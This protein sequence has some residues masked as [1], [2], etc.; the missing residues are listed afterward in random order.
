MNEGWK[1]FQPYLKTLAR[2]PDSLANLDPETTRE[3]MELILAGTATPAQA[4]GFLLIGRAKGNSAGEL[5]GI[6][7]A[8]RN[9][10][11]PIAVAT[12]DGAPVVTVTGGFD[13]KLRTFNVGA[14]SSLVAAAAGAK[15]VLAG[16]EDM[17]PKAGRTNFDAL[18]NLGVEAPQPLA[19]S[20]R[21]LAGEGFAATTPEHYLPE[22]HA[23]L[24]LRREMVRRTALNVSEKLVSPVAGSRMM[25]GMTHRKPFI[26]TMPAALVDLGVE[27][28]LIF[29]AIEGSDEAPL[30]GTSALVKIEGGSIQEFDVSPGSLGLSRATRTAI[31]WDGPEDEARRLLAAL[32]G[33]EGPVRDLILYNAALRLWLS[34]DDDRLPERL[35]EARSA[36]DSGRARRLLD[37]LRRSAVTTND[38]R[39]GAG[40]AAASRH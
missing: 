35:D 14:V 30:D 1:E 24:Q 13:G 33:E 36:L 3:A 19:A 40:G 17:P 25:V 34:G 9:F 26:E 15:I 8:M 29:Q 21:S 37:R 5:A 28:A 6:S 23:L 32:D 27:K 4:A 38:R 31:P 39:S 12:P 20:K 18:R 7:R 10:R 2:G 22:L 16:G 11:R